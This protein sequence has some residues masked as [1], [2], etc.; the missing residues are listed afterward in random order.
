MKLLT[1]IILILCITTHV[2]SAQTQIAEIS[3]MI[4]ISCQNMVKK[5]IKKSCPEANINISWREEIA[6]ISFESKSN[7][8]V[9][10]LEK[11]IIETGFDVGKIVT[12]DKLI[13][14]PKIAKKFVN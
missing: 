7:V 6:L 1:K 5:I 8:T 3:G 12:V 11:I 13:V 4:C 14:D 2:F 10:Q 9:D